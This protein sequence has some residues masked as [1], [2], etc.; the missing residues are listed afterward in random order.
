M[1]IS[2]TMFIAIDEFSPARRTSWEESVSMWQVSVWSRLSFLTAV[3]G[4]SMN[5]GTVYAEKCFQRL[6][7]AWR[8]PQGSLSPTEDHNAP[9][10]SRTQRAWELGLSQFPWLLSSST[11]QFPHRCQ[12]PLHRQRKVERSDQGYSFFFWDSECCGSCYISVGVKWKRILVRRKCYH[13]STEP[14]A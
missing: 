9:S 6:E 11:E 3:T 4:T 10:L 7:S 1:F 2:T 8:C 14:V 13:Y 5:L 12:L